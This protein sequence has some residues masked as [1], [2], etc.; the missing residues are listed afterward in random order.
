MSHNLTKVH[1]IER[2]FSQS[3]TFSFNKILSCFISLM[4]EIFSFT[5]ISQIL[6][7]LP[8]LMKF[9]KAVLP[10]YKNEGRDEFLLSWP[11][12]THFINILRVYFMAV[13]K[14][15]DVVAARPVVAA[16]AVEAVRA[17]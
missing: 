11:P 5:R 4:N 3:K 7:V 13:E 2:S 16:L 15:A 6:T 12:I 14:V 1:G 10:L 17:V 8:L 9:E